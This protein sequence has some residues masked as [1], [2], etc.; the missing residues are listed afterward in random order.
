MPLSSLPA[1]VRIRAAIDHEQERMLRMSPRRRWLLGAALLLLPAALLVPSCSSTY[2]NR[3]PQGEPFPAVVGES[4]EEVRTELPGDFAGAPIVLL[5]GYEQNTQF[6]IDR[7]AMGLIQAGVGARLV[8]VPTIPSLVASW[9]SGWIDDGM[10]S[11]IPEEDWGAVVTIYGSAAEPIAK[12]T[13]TEKGRNARILVLD[14]A[15]RI[16]WFDDQGYSVAKALEIAAL[17]ES[18]SGS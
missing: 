8:E 16:A 2:P 6:D 17:L 1:A 4:L 14:A 12:L 3:N 7:W 15:G 18:L 13:G 5:V 11:G 10:R 9:A